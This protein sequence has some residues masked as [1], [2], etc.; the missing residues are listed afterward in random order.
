[1]ITVSIAGVLPSSVDVDDAATLNLVNAFDLDAAVPSHR[2][3]LSVSSNGSPPIVRHP[4]ISK[5]FLQRSFST[6]APSVAMRQND[7]SDSASD[8]PFPLRC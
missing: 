2:G 4:I 7:A 6:I 3:V 5:S 8:I 1:L